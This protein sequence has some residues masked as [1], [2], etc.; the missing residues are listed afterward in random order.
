MLRS[1]F[2]I[3]LGRKKVNTKVQDLLTIFKLTRKVKVWV[4]CKKKFKSYILKRLCTWKKKSIFNLH[5]TDKVLG[6]DPMQLRSVILGLQFHVIYK[7]NTSPD[8]SQTQIPSQQM[9]RSS[10]REA[11]RIS[12]QDCIWVTSR[13]SQENLSHTLQALN[14]ARWIAGSSY[15]STPFQL[16]SVS[17]L[18]CRAHYGMKGK[19]ILGLPKLWEH[20][21]A[22]RDQAGEQERLEQGAIVGLQGPLENTC[23]SLQMKAPGVVALEPGSSYVQVPATGDTRTASEQTQHLSSAAD[24]LLQRVY[25]HTLTPR[26]PSCSNRTVSGLSL[27]ALSLADTHR[28]HPCLLGTHFGPNWPALRHEAAVALLL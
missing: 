14:P 27:H 4:D 9:Q 21:S 12:K 19:G 22:N 18:G 16:R 10:G 11:G 2:L 1:T 8:Y 25:A 15:P 28:P 5:V 26:A 17:A 3:Q 7:N 13:L 20:A 23:M 24:R 6:S